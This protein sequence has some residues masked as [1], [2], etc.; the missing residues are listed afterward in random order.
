MDVSLSWHLGNNTKKWMTP[1]TPGFQQRQHTWSTWAR[2]LVYTAV[3]IES[4]SL[5][6]TKKQNIDGVPMFV[7]DLENYCL[8]E[9]DHWAGTRGARHRASARTRASELRFPVGC[10]L[11]GSKVDHSPTNI[12]SLTFTGKYQE[13]PL[14][15]KFDLKKKRSHVGHRDRGPDEANPV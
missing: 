7:K 4:S 8:M 5:Q 3:G 14:S 12:L 10:A 2:H 9:N 15:H 1:R 6:L 11:K 13:F